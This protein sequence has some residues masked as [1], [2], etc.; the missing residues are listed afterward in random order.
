[1]KKLFLVAVLALG[2]SGCA[3]LKN[4]WDLTTGVQVSPRAVYVA[5]N[6]FNGLEATAANYLHICAGN[7]STPGCAPKAISQLIPATRSGRLT[8]DA[9]RNFVIAHPDALGAKGLYDALRTSTAVIKGISDTYK[10]TGVTQ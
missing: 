10:I 3:G 9:L 4:A 6:V 8:R 5:I 1:M 2:L 7:M